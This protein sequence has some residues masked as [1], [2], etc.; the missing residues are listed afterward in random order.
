MTLD[1]LLICKRPYAAQRVAMRTQFGWVNKRWC[2][3]HPEPVQLHSV[4]DYHITAVGSSLAKLRTP[5][6]YSELVAYTRRYDG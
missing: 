4:H 2:K 1:T 3:S 5:I 6:D